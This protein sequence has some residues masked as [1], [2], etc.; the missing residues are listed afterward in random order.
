[1]SFSPVQMLTFGSPTVP[2]LSAAAEEDDSGVV[3]VY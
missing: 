3:W 2:L 1:M